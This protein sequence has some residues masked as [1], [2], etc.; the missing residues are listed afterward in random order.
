MGS[1]LELAFLIK[2]VD[3]A[4]EKLKDVSG[5]MGKLGGLGKAAGAL[6]AGGIAIAGAAVVGLG[7]GLWDCTQEAM[8]AELVQAQLNAVLESTGGAAGITAEKANELASSLSGVT[9]FEDDTILSGENMLLTFTN[10]GQDVFP[11]ATATMLDMSQ[12]MGQDLQSSAIQLGK[13]LNDPV[14]GMSALQRVGVTFTDDQKKQIE[15]MMASGDVMGAQKVI[16]GELSKEFGGAAEA[17]GGTFAGKMEILKNKMGDVKESIG[18]ALLPGLGMLA[19]KLLEVFNDPVVQEA[20]NK[21]VTW[22]GTN[23]PIAIEAV[24]KWFEEDLPVAIATAKEWL[25][26]MKE[27]IE[28]Q[29]EKWKDFKDR[30]VAVWLDVTGAIETAK[31]KIQKFLEPI[32]QWFNDVKTAIQGVVDWVQS[33]IDKIQALAEQYLPDWLIGHSP[34]PMAQWLGQIAGAAGAASVTLG[35]MGQSVGNIEHHYNLTIQTSAQAEQV[36]GD[37]ALMQVM[38]G[39]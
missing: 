30:V 10:I 12:A 33:L 27:W 11:E 23:L 36:A 31:T 34:P 37:F 22:I 2:V 6:A 28:E 24:V 13:A 17:A 16:L 9:M 32:I 26:K 7:K 20:I 14:S 15:T 5:S 35:A 38:A 21:I 18:T 8:E 4:T 39:V 1:A 25:Q 3:E 19:D 29:R